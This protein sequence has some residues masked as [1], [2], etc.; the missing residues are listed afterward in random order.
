MK[1]IIMCGGKYAGWDIPRQLSVINGECLVERTIR[2]LRECG[3][4]DIAIS[5]LDDRFKG[6]SVPVLEHD[7]HYGRDRN[8]IW[9]DAFYPMDEPVCYMYGDVFY[10]PEAVRHIVDHDTKGIMFFASAAPFAP[11]YIKK[12]AEPFAFKVYDTKAFR[13][14]I[15]RT[16]Y[17]YEMR[18][19]RRAISWELWQV[20]MKTPLNRIIQNYEV[21]NDYTCDIDSPEEIKRIEEILGGK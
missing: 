17:Y 9:L 8:S 13:D 20:I 1:Y 5:S 12:W 10:S 18:V 3:V 14:A 6:L 19:L 7:N 15:A 16:R 2:L 11:E 21:I 4:S